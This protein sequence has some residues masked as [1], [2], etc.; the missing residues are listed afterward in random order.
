MTRS[1]ANSMM[2][3]PSTGRWL[4]APALLLAAAIWPGASE[5]Y[6]ATNE[7]ASVEIR[8]VRLQGTAEIIRAGATAGVKTSETN[9]VLYPADRM[10]VGRNSRVT[11]RWSDQSVVTCDAL[12]EIE[13]LSPHTRAAEPGLRLIKGILSFFH[14]D[15]PG[16]IRVVTRGAVAGVEGTEFAVAVEP[17]N[18]AERTTLSVIDG[19]VHFSNEQGALDLT[20]GGQAVAELGKAPA[21]TAGFIVNNLLQWCF[22]YPAVLDPSELPLTPEEQN[23]LR[24]SLT[25][26]RAGD[27][28]AALDNYP[29]GRQPASDAERVYYAALVLSVG[30]VTP[31]EAALSALT[32]AE[33]SER[34]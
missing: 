11:L 21:P 30:Q 22:Y 12:T 18:D 27:L 10:R 24:E 6:S 3:V 25:A 28:L 7:L 15:T 17:A 32:P 16:R 23:I 26:Y 5:G 2:P 29:L 1:T 8:I 13:I 20:N 19:K 33:P 9:Q 4:V 34:L 14:R 31:A